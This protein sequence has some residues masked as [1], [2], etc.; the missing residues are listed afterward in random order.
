MNVILTG[1]LT[2][3]TEEQVDVVREFLPRQVEL[4]CVEPGCLGCEV[5]PVT[6]SLTRTVRERFIDESAFRAHRQG[7][8]T[9]NWGRVTAGIECRYKTQGLDGGGAHTPD[10]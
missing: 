4:T 1:E 3:R 2:C 6:D 5:L 8:A 10:S 7:V 9:I